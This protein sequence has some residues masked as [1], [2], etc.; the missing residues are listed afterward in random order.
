MGSGESSEATAD[1]NKHYG[2][3]VDARKFRA[4]HP[5]HKVRITQPFYLG[6]YHVT[7][8]QF[9]R[10]AADANYKTDAENGLRPGTWAPRDEDKVEPP[11]WRN[12]GFER[13]TSTRW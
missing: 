7:R 1:F 5:Q 12:A 4:E 9:R 6:K 2:E 13:P 11:S 8:G 3:Q 10:F